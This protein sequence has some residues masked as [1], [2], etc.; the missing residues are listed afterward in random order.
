MVL[1]WIEAS[2]IATVSEAEARLDALR[3]HGLSP[4]VFTVREAFPPP[5]AATP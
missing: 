5:A 3:G 1:R 4:E 2:H